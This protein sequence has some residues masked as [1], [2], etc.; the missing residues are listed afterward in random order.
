MID[1]KFTN[2]LNRLAVGDRIVV[3]KSGIRLIQHHA[4]YLGFNKGEHW[5]IENKEIIGVR[6]VTATVFFNGVNRVTRVEQFTPSF[7]YGRE[8]LLAF[9]LTKVGTKYHLINYNCESFANEIQGK[10]VTSKQANNGIATTAS[11]FV[12][13][14]LILGFKR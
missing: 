14:I 4:I 12:F 11:I 1:S 10:E 13:F 6:V 8:Q 9:A 3:P 5:F 2:L 7:D